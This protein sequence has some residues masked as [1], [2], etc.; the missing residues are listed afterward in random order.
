MSTNSIPAAMVYRPP[1]LFLSSRDFLAELWNAI[2]KHVDGTPIAESVVVVPL[3]DSLSYHIEWRY[4]PSP[5]GPR[6]WERDDGPRVQRA[7]GEQL[8]APTQQPP[9][10]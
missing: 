9:H 7:T 5:L 8:Y 2:A 1:S 6:D 3:Y 10:L 4:L